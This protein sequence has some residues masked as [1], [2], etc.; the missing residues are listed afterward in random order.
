MNRLAGHVGSIC[1]ALALVGVVLS[2]GIAIANPGPSQTKPA[3]AKAYLQ[4][5]WGRARAWQADAELHLIHNP[6]VASDG[7]NS[8]SATSTWSYTFFSK[9]ANS[10]YM[11]TATVDGAV[12]GFEAPPGVVRPDLMQA[13]P[14]DFLDS[15]QAMAAA[16][17]GGFRPAS[18][19]GVT[20][21]KNPDEPPTWRIE[22]FKLHAV[23]GKPLTK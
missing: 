11:V 1:G 19:N 2:A 21:E 6:E 13:L 16:R 14:K 8:A 20:L 3:T 15:D 7:R 9:K 18:Q 17:A 5:A 4:E 12:N 10:A 22:G 23:T